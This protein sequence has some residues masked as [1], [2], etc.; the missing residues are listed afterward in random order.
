MTRLRAEVER[1]C[2][3]QQEALRMW[4]EGNPWMLVKRDEALA[5]FAALEKEMER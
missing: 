5:A 1:L 2:R 4:E 3:Q